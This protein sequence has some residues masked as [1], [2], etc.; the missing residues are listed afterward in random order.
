[1]APP[2]A[3]SPH[4]SP[5]CD[6]PPP[7]HRRPHPR[8][9][10]A[11]TQA[12]RRR[13]V[14]LTARRAPPAGPSVAHTH[15]P[16]SRRYRP[17]APHAGSCPP[18][19]R[20]SRRR[21]PPS[22]GCAP[23][24]V[25]RPDRHR[26][27]ER[28]YTCCRRTRGQRLHARTARARR[29]RHGVAGYAD[30]GSP[31]TPTPTDEAIRPDDG[32]CRR[33]QRECLRPARVVAVTIAVAVA[34]ALALARRSGRS[35]GAGRSRATSCRLRPCRRPASPRQNRS[36]PLRRVSC[37]TGRRAVLCGPPDRPLGGRVVHPAR[38]RFV[39]SPCSVA[40]SAACR[41]V[42]GAT[43]PVFVFV[44]ALSGSTRPRPRRPSL[45]G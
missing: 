45:G 9:T 33:P 2:P 39:A 30:T 32:A 1:M 3:A 8:T 44:P 38:G 20:R 41:P 37:R 17:R 7:R 22:P 11:K 40:A 25:T 4:D 21:R 42:G 15:P 23:R 31:D 18:A 13:A 14:P 24:S 28:R 35:T 43:R 12:S 36:R 27:A 26:P 34:P 5:L 6:G 29:L 10:G 16:P 19:E